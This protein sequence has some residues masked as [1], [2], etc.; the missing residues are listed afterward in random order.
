MVVQLK[1]AVRQAVVVQLKVAVRQAVAAVEQDRH[2]LQ[3]AFLKQAMFLKHQ[4]SLPGRQR[5]RQQHL[6]AL[7][8]ERLLRQ[9][10][11]LQ[12]LQRETDLLVE[13]YDLLDLL[14]IYLMLS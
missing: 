14:L 8:I 10:L 5:H 9:V 2:L 7:Q 12:A 4:G 11:E 13:W 3:V 1:V 6:L